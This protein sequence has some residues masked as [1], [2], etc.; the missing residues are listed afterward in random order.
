MKNLVRFGISIPES[1][2]DKFDNYIKK[3]GYTNRSKAIADL[4]RKSLIQEEWEE[5]KEVVGGVIL[6]YNHHKR[7]LVE[8]LMEIEHHHISHIISTQ[9]I[10]LDKDNCLE[11]AVVRGKALEVENLTGELGALKGVKFCGLL[12]ASLGKNLE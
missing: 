7:K 1:L 12:K 8:E 5:N 4:I 9:H 3:R 6:L 11:I 2:R 10:H